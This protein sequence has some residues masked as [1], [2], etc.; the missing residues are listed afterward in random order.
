[1]KHTTS[2]NGSTVNVIKFLGDLCYQMIL[3]DGSHYADQNCIC[4]LA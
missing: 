4:M 2:L 1:M 3:E